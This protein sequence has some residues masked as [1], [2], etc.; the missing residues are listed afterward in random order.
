MPSIDIHHA[1]SKT[2]A[3]ARKALEDV[4]KKLAERFDMQYD[5]DGDTLNFMRSGVDGKIKLAPKKLHVTAQLGFMLSFL[6]D[7]IES[8]IQRVLRE[9]FD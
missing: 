7:S 6:K 8:E 9:K 2:P 3:Q 4:A 1:H 5:W